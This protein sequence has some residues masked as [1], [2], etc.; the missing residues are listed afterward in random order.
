MRGY[1]PILIFP[2]NDR[3]PLPGIF[4]KTIRF[5]KAPRNV[6]IHATQHIPLALFLY[7]NLQFLV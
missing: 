3:F 1:C 4:Y 7:K 2:L 6:A 5:T